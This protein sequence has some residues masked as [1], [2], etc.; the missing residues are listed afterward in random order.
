[1]LI[2]N[3]LIADNLR[4]KKRIAQ[5]LS[6]GAQYRNPTHHKIKYYKGFENARKQWKEGTKIKELTDL[7]DTMT[8]FNEGDIVK[9]TA[10]MIYEFTAY[11]KSNGLLAE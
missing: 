7:A 11:M 6:N 1:M 10:N 5:K 3:F 2:S 4:I 9:R 8:D